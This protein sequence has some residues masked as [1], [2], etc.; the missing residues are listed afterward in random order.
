MGALLLAC[1]ATSHSAKELD[2]Y[3]HCGLLLQA[4]D[5]ERESF[6]IMPPLLMGMLYRHLSRR[7]AVRG[8]HSLEHDVL[9]ACYQ[10]MGLDTFSTSAAIS[11]SLFEEQCAHLL[12]LR[13]LLLKAQNKTS[14]SLEELL[15]ASLTSDGGRY[16]TRDGDRRTQFEM[17]STPCFQLNE[18]D[19]MEIEDAVQ[20][21]TARGA[22]YKPTRNNYEGVDFLVHFPAGQLVAVQCRFSLPTSSTTLDAKD[23]PSCINKFKSSYPNLANHTS[24]FVFLALRKAAGNVTPNPGTDCK[25]YPSGF[26]VAVLS[27]EDVVAITPHSM[28]E[29]PQFLL[30]GVE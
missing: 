3:C 18:L 19:D 13:L 21:G 14:F 30:K 4:P 29:R 20:R 5:K 24:A 27:Q 9:Q 12:R 23:V 25:G 10:F 6:A 1:S 7:E 26:E 17:P 22:I 15:P 11:A 2:Q 28:R 16:W 8:V